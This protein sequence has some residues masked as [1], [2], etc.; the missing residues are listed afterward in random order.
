MKVHPGLICF[1]FLSLQDGNIG[2]ISA[3]TYYHTVPEGGQ[4]ELECPSSSASSRKFF[5]T[6]TCKQE[7][8]LIDT[9]EVSAQSGRYSIGPR[10]GQTSSG[11]VFVN[12]S[13]VTK[14]DSG[15]YRC[16]VG[17]FLSSATYVKTEIIVVDALLNED[18]RETHTLYAKN[19]GNIKVACFFSSLFF[20]VR[21]AF[22]CRGEE[23]FVLTTKTD[24]DTGQSGRHTIRYVKFNTGASVYVSISQL[25]RSDSGRYRCGLERSGF[26][27]LDREFKVNV[28]D[29][30][31]TAEPNS[32]TSTSVPTNEHAASTES[33][34]Q[35]GTSTTDILLYAGLT[36]VALVVLFSLALLIFCR[37]KFWKPKGRGDRDSLNM[38]IPTYENHPSVSAPEDSIY[39]SLDT[40][41]RDQ[42]QTYSTLR[43]KTHDAAG[44]Q[45]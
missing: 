43:H 27:D 15:R 1:F 14:S 30:S 20:T 34:E 19:G 35:S 32:V 9:E 39:Q 44:T 41:T 38:E 33:T 23:C 4:A 7:D 45:A 40:A 12:I 29:E 22:L 5:C 3:Q 31:P 18:R 25:N 36:G 6:E 8:I 37:R 11:D 26:L 17:R 2:F 42:D 28:T 13:N 21:R 24:D 16:G 10:K